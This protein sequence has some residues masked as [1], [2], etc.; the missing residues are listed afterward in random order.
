MI[1]VFTG[2]VHS[3]ALVGDKTIDN[4][5]QGLGSVHPLAF[6]YIRLLSACHDCS[7]WKH[8]MPLIPFLC[9][10]LYP[11]PPSRENINLLLKMVCEGI[12]TLTAVSVVLG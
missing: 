7:V 1:V 10:E 12:H 5:L 11:L 2:S 3:L 8:G 9:L 6:I 4:K